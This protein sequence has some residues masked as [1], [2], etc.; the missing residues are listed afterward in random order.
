[1]WDDNYI[2]LL[3]GETK[4]L[5]AYFSKEDLNSDEPVLKVSGWNVI[6]D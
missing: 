2:S 1:Y 4:E 5:H 6:T 3:P